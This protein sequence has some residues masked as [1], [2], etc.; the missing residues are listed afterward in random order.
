MP[1]TSSTQ[2]TKCSS[3]TDICLATYTH[4]RGS[5][6]SYSAML[7]IVKG[8]FSAGLAL[9]RGHQ[10]TTYKGTDAREGRSIWLGL[11][12][13]QHHCSSILDQ[14]K[15]SLIEIQLN[16][17]GNSLTDVVYTIL[18]FIVL[19]TKAFLCQDN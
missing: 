17:Q 12:G 19:P 10:K 4:I 6:L 3:S 16:Q 13:G 5:T 18:W 8:E 7:F 9:S 1:E 14:L 15:L 2:Q 11:G